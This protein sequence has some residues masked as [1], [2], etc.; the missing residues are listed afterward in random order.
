METLQAYANFTLANLLWLLLALPVI[1]LPAA[2]AGLAAVMSEWTRNPQPSRPEALPV[3]FAAF[4]KQFLRA[5]L[6]AVTNLLLMLPLALNALLAIGAGRLPAAAGAMLPE[7]TGAVPAAAALPLLDGT[8]LP[9]VLLVPS[10]ALSMAALLFLAAANLFLWPLLVTSRAPL[11]QLWRT[12][13]R[14]VLLQPFT[15][16]LALL[17]CAGIIGLS[18]FLPKAVLLFVTAAAV[19]Y[20]ASRCA[21]RVL[22]RHDLPPSEVNN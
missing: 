10:G 15:A 3:F 5:T 20:T 11:R 1:T 17:L 2:T 22:R 7:I 14:L 4:R 6:L 13:C 16:L 8:T 12:A 21:W 18:L 9:Q 19:S